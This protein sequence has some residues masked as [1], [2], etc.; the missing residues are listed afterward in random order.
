M[1]ENTINQ[2]DYEQREL[3]IQKLE[4]VRKK[5]RESEENFER[6]N[7]VTG[8]TIFL[9]LS[10]AGFYD[11]LQFGLN[12]IP[13]L[14]STLSIMV[15]IFSWLTFYTWTSIKGWGFSDTIKKAGVSL[16]QNKDFLKWI[17]K[18]CPILGVIPIFNWG[19]EIM[20]GVF[21][22]IL[23]VKSDDFVYNKT[24]GK[25]DSEIIKEGLQFFNVFRNVY[26]V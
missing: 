7:R 11:L 19:P 18:F 14:G 5:V 25:V 10:V 20:G 2:P 16:F 21:L 9:M 23:I 12:F 4:E 13:I 15:G 8:T 26:N 17:A 1:E 24:K 3:V 22:T 6:R